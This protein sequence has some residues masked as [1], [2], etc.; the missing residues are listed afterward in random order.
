MALVDDDVLARAPQSIGL[1][2]LGRVLV[3]V[4]LAIAVPLRLVGARAAVFFR[5][6]LSA[7]PHDVDDRAH[8]RAADLE[9]FPGLLVQK[10]RTDQPLF[11]QGIAERV[12]GV[13]DG[14]REDLIGVGRSLEDR[15]EVP[16]GEFCH[17]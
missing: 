4:H 12:H 13:L 10:V 5:G 2:D 3:L 9:K 7:A 14:V 6:G 15:D 16:L 11:G 17:R 8:L 1:A